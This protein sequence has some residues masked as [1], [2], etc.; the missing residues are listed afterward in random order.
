M[1]KVIRTNG[2]IESLKTD[3]L[4]VGD[5]VHLATGDIVPADLRLFQGFNLESNEAL[6][7]GESLP[8]VKIRSAI[9]D[10]EDVPIGDRTSM[11]YS[12]STVTKSRGVGIVV[13]TA[14]RTE[15]GRIA[16]LLNERSVDKESTG[17]LTRLMKKATNLL[18][19]PLVSSERLFRSSSAGLRSF[20][21]V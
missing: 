17:Q 16:E 6:L 7:T 14:G 21:S 2:H 20:Y 4:V 13:A 8:I 15:V 19:R 5:I 18:R 12:A 1:C 11:V 10:K 9:L 3:K